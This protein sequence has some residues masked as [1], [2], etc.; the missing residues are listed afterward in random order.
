MTD[1]LDLPARHRR[2]VEA[3]LA[4]HVPDAEVWA[5]GS[6]VKGRSHPASDLD[7]VLRS[8]TLEPIP[9]S[10]LA[11]LEEALEQSNIPI[12]IQAH[13]WVRLPDS[14]HKEVMK[15][16]V[17]LQ[18][19]PR[20]R[21]A[22]HDDW[23]TIRLGDACTKIGSGATPRGGSKAYLTEGPYALIRSQN[24]H[25]DRFRREGLVYIDDDQARKLNNVEVYEGDV[26]LNITGDSV[27]RSCRVDP[28]VVPARVNQHVAIVRTDRSVLSPSFLRYALIEPA[29]QEQL[30][31]LAGSGG[32][33]KALTKRDI[34]ALSV[35]AP[36]SVR[37]QERLS[38]ILEALDTKIEL[39]QRMSKTLEEIAQA[40]FKSWFVDF[41][42]VRAK[43]AGQ[44]SGL[45][46]DLDSLFSS[47]FQPTELGPIPYG[48]NIRD[49]GDVIQTTTGRSYRRTD[50]AE[51]DTAL[52]TLKS[53]KRGG[54]YRS[55]GLKSY[56]GAYKPEQIVH[57]GDV[58]VSCTDVTQE[59]DV[60]GRPAVVQPTRLFRRLVASLDVMIVRPTQENITMSFLYP[61][62]SA[63]SFVSYAA[64]RT[65]GTTVLHLEKSCV[66]TYRFVCP[67]SLVS[68]AF[69][70]MSEPIHRCIQ[71][72]H[73]E[74]E[75]I[76][77]IRDLLLPRLIAGAK[78]AEHL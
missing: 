68:M 40:I 15:Q 63:P 4:E 60:I 16:Y 24:V 54:G 38:G 2:E 59:A 65:A 17:I 13:D 78:R 26:L 22:R 19:A 30:L 47:S 53:F 49:L 42:P 23:T 27:A 48:W 77:V 58:I 46:P 14:F 21:Q 74:I 45:P 35:A 69:N 50:L 12:L 44:P 56:V 33:R 76:A 5:Y 32:T 8:P 51:S 73:E 61:L 55:S 25:N 71:K 70:R 75:G 9:V 3:L 7:L 39:N 1:R 20:E 43:E 64:S 28:E 10:Q 31:S 52:V 62:M 67:P 57:P 18:A 66:E 41:D 72:I 11:D 29:M 37:H 34:T 6:R 36:Q